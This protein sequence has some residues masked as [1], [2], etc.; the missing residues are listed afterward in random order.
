MKMIIR[1]FAMLCTVVA[2][3][4]TAVFADGISA[5]TT[6]NSAVS[7]E[8][9]E[10]GAEK[11]ALTVTDSNAAAKQ[12]LLFALN[13]NASGVIPNADNIVYIDQLTADSNGAAAFTVF[14][15]ADLPDGTYYL[16][17]S[18]DAA[19]GTFAALTEVG[20]FTYGGGSQPVESDVKTGDVDGNSSV[21]VADAAV[22][23]NY[24]VGSVS[25]SAEQLKAADVDKNNSV[26]VADAAMIVNYAVG[27]ISAFPDA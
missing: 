6:T 26:N 1:R 13:T 5:V 24:S 9:P 2:L 27:N 18:S 4:T 14:P 16:Y 25:L 3:A 23:V 7:A 12:I 8:Q 22:I 19:T 10:S 17:V 20:N 11:F 15:K 21:N